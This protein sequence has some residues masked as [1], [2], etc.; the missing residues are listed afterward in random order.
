M[1]RGLRSGIKSKQDLAYM[2][3]D[4]HILRRPI[5]GRDIRYPEVPLA[6]WPTV[7]GGSRAAGPIIVLKSRR[8]L[9]ERTIYPSNFAD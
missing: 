1:S 7:S 6:Y 5:Y 4:V 9:E 3:L 8:E 2:M